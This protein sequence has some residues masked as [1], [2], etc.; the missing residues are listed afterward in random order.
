MP[1][2]KNWTNIDILNLFYLVLPHKMIMKQRSMDPLI[3]DWFLDTFSWLIPPGFILRPLIGLIVKTLIVLNT[4]E[5]HEKRLLYKWKIWT[6]E[7]FGF[8][9][10]ESSWIVVIWCKKCINNFWM[11]MMHGK[12]LQKIRLD[13][14]SDR[15]YRFHCH[16][17]YIWWCS[18]TCA[19]NINLLGPYSFQYLPL[20]SPELLMF[21]LRMVLFG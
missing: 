11:K 4:L 15:W 6:L 16:S 14:F 12:K 3:L 17:R 9:K 7:I 20:C 18:V 10:E 19:S 2:Q 1:F 8:G 5:I 13:N 21:I